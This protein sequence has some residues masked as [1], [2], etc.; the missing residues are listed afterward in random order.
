MFLTLGGPRLGPSTFW[1]LLPACARWEPAYAGAARPSPG[2][3]VAKPTLDAPAGGL[4]TI[5]R[6]EPAPTPGCSPTRD[7]GGSPPL[8]DVP[9]PASKPRL[10]R[11][12]YATA[13][14]RWTGR[15]GA[16][17]RW[18]A[19]GAAVAELM[20]RELLQA[21]T[22]SRTLPRR[23]R[24]RFGCW[25]FLDLWRIGAPRSPADIEFLL[26]RR[27]VTAALRQTPPGPSS[28]PPA[29]T[30]CP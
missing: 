29:A 11:L 15:S 30:R 19:T 6:R 18:R 21:S 16:A 13:V 4:D 2:S 14:N 28:P 10:I 23:Y 12:K 1:D 26:H 20:W 7:L 22:R 5:Q 25:G 9:L 3:A 8:A 17:S 27:S 24:D